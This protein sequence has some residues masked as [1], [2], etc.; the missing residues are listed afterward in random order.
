MP[1]TTPIRS[2]SCAL[3]TALLVSC[4]P[5]VV[6]VPTV[7]TVERPPCHRGDDEPPTTDAEPMTPA[8]VAAHRELVA[9]AWR[10]HVQC[11]PGK[12]RP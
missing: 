10:V 4:Q 11:S 2:L 5:H 9:Y 12:V 7:V 8:W 6:K 3:L 1:R